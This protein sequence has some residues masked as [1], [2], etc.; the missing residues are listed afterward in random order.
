MLILLHFTITQNHYHPHFT[1]S[2]L[3]LGWVIDVLHI[4]RGKKLAEPGYEH[5][6]SQ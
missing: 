3:K 1:G 6:A 2:I 5:R 4:P